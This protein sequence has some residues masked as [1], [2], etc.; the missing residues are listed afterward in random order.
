MDLGITSRQWV[1]IGTCCHR[2]D[3]MYDD[4]DTEGKQDSLENTTKS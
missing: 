2:Y 4:D 1:W 3:V